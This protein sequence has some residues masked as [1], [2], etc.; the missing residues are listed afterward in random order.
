MNGMSMV[1]PPEYISRVAGALLDGSYRGSADSLMHLAIMGHPT[2]SGITPAMA[3]ANPAVMECVKK[4]IG[5]Y[6]GFIRK[7]VRE[8][9]VYHHTPVIPG[10]DGKGW[11]ALEY[12]SSD[13]TKAVAA[14]FRLVNAPGDCYRF[15][16]RG[17]DSGLNYRLTFEPGGFEA[18]AN[19]F[20]LSNDGIEI[21]LESALTSKLILVQ[22]E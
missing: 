13:R 17:L 6:K 8:A 4:Y 18:V 5:I 15:V 9:R 11:C 21:R 22:A 14:V 19:G 12:V 3:E 7:F 20:A 10:G 2:L 16:F 1:L